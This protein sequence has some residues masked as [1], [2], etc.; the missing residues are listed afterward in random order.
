MREE[1]MHKLLVL[2]GHP[3]DEAHFRDYYVNKHLPLASKMP[4]VRNTHF[5]FDIVALG[6]DKAPYFCIFEAEFESADALRA[7]FASPEGK[8]TA[9]DVP[10]YATGGVTILHHPI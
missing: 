9:A 5:S 4:G 8:A 6:A 7:A 2:Y 10:N 1:T 3:K